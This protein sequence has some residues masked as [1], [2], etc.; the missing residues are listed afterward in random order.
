MK[1]IKRFL[2][3]FF[4]LFI[5]WV[6]LTG[7]DYQEMILGAGISILIS[8]LFSR[9]LGIYGEFRFSV[10][11]IIYGILYIFVFLG[12]LIK[13][14]I[15]VALRVI[16]PVIPINPGIVHV[17]T[18]LKSPLARLVLANSITLTPGTLTVETSGEDFYIHWIDVKAADETGATE[19][20]V[21]NFEKYLEV[22]FG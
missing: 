18:T 21:K 9:H 3:S 11:A 15:D 13:S 5:L 19:A 22:I 17:K 16:Q 10:K 8:L 2:F 20:I 1:A 6:L 12:A 14:N 4:F 7:L